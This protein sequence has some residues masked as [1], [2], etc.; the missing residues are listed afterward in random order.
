MTLPVQ[1]NITLSSPFTSPI[2]G[3]L[4]APACIAVDQ[5]TIC[6]RTMIQVVILH[7]KRALKRVRP[8]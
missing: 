2:T 1:Q 6:A 3:H 7:A 4:I 5:G 8:P